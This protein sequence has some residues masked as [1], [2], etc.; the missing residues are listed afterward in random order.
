MDWNERTQSG[1]FVYSSTNSAVL[2]NIDFV[3][4][5]EQTFAHSTDLDGAFPT[6]EANERGRESLVHS[7]WGSTR[8]GGA[9]YDANNSLDLSP[10]LS[11][12]PIEVQN[13]PL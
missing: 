2:Q 9:G 8:L 12:G 4:A 11:Q 10:S 7:Q 1:R 13:E 6:F 3:V 5:N